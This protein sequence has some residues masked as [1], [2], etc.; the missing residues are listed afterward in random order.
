MYFDKPILTPATEAINYPNIK[1]NYCMKNQDYLKLPKGEGNLVIM[2]S[3]SRQATFTVIESG[4]PQFYKCGYRLYTTDTRIKTVIGTRTIN[5]NNP[6]EFKTEFRKA[7]TNPAIRFLPFTS[8]NEAL[9]KG[10]QLIYDMGELNKLYFANRKIKPVDV[11]CQAYL[12]YLLQNIDRFD[13]SL[14]EKKIIYISVTEWNKIGCKFGIMK[15]MMDNPVSMML[16]IL[17]KKPV[18]LK[19]FTDRG[20]EFL[21]VNEDEK[22]FIKLTLPD[23]ITENGQNKQVYNKFRLNMGKMKINAPISELEDEED[24]QKSENVKQIAEDVK[25]EIISKPPVIKPGSIRNSLN[26]GNIAEARR[27]LLKSY[28][29]GS[30]TLFEDTMLET[31]NE[32]EEDEQENTEDLGENNEEEM[33]QIINEENEEIKDVIDNYVKGNKKLESDDLSTADKKQAIEDEVKEKVYIAKFVPE[34]SAKQL[35]Y[36]DVGYGKQ[37]QILNQS[38]DE[39]KSKIIDEDT[40]DDK[41]VHVTNETLKTIRYANADKCYVEKK[42]KPDIN[43]AVAAM[44]N[45]DIKVF[46]EGIDEV[47]SSDQLNQKKT[48]TYHLVDENGKKHTLTFDVPIIFDGCYLY[49]GGERKMIGHQRIF[50]PIVKIRPDTVQLVTF[51]NKIQIERWGSATDAETS[52][53][54]KV[55]SKNKFF[56]VSYGN[57]R[58]KN[59]KYRTSLEFDDFARAFTHITYRSKYEY[60]VDIYFDLP[61]AEREYAEYAKQANSKPTDFVEHIWNIKLTR[62]DGKVDWVTLFSDEGT[63]LSDEPE[64]SSL[65]DYIKNTVPANIEKEISTTKGG[66]RFSYA[67]AKILNKFVPLVFFMLFCEGFT[68]V[69]RKCNIKYEIFR[70]KKEISEIYGSASPTGKSVIQVAD[71]FILYS[72]IPYENAILMNGLVDIAPLLME[73][74]L[75]ELDSKDTY[76]DILSIYYASSNQAKN[77]DKFRMFLIDKKTEEILKDFN[78]PTDLIEVLFYACKLLTSNQY[79]PDNDMH[80]MRI[81]SNEI[82]PQIIYQYVVEAYGRFYNTQNRKRPEK[83]SMPKDAVIKALMSSSMVDDASIVNPI[84]NLEKTRTCTIKASTSAKNITLTGINKTDGY[85]MDKRAF[86][87][88]MTGIFG[89]T[90]DNGPNV[91]I[92]R[93]LALEPNVTS[94]NGYLDVTDKEDLESLNAANIFTAVELLTPPGVLHDDPQRSA[95]MRSQTSKMVLV[96]KAQPVLIGNKVES[97]VPYHLNGDFSFAA[98]EDGKVIDENNG[99]YVVQYKSG[100]YESFDTNERVMKNSSDGSYTRI[101]FETRVKVGDSFKKNE[102]LAVEPTAMSFNHDDRGASCN[103][104]VLAKVAI[105]SLYDVFEDSEPI[106][107]SLSRKLGYWRIQKKSVSLEANTYVEKIAK[108]GDHIN[109]G[110]PLLVFDSSRGDPEVQKYLDSLRKGM[111]NS[112]IAEEIVESNNTVISSPTTGEIADIKIYATVPVEQLSE[113]LQKIVTQYRKGIEKDEKFLDKYKNPGDNKYYKCGKLF[114]ETTDTIETKYGKVKGEQVGDGVLIEFYIKDHDYVKKGDKMTEKK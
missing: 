4:F 21:F 22:N 5:V 50:K 49:I 48:L 78:L 64:N 44:S 53:I 1:N 24:T 89:L 85:G 54:K 40:I 63:G 58:A 90:S 56:D 26:K 79:L 27:T 39:M 62:K 88:S 113:S 82:I 16:R 60:K 13:M 11:M 25:K 61:E 17:M 69:M 41:V 91:G 52:A 73:Y 8:I 94:T 93:E 107:T 70:T 86:D 23:N 33:E 101:K 66:R 42:L 71:A 34:K 103:I 80:N 31:E 3:P 10:S 108:V 6:T 2:M 15:D 51:Y 67:R 92:V 38:I 18:L 30:S 72:N 35:K 45:A 98:K 14:Y 43:N 104:G 65:T 110:E 75:E 81:R 100:K 106:T 57:A 9:A 7:V 47:D 87:P 114:T 95:M 28:G 109:L 99:I 96:D 19:E 83:I 76:I 59:V 84:Y 111:A 20:L 29:R 105:M 37:N 97:I 77:L 36:I 102:I 12:T 112:G 74:T 32:D 68:S 55:I 46:I